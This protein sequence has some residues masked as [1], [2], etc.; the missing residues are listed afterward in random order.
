MDAICPSAI[1]SLVH[2]WTTLHKDLDVKIDATEGRYLRNVIFGMDDELVARLLAAKLSMSRTPD[3]CGG[4][5]LARRGS[6]VDYAVQGQSFSA[7]LVHGTSSEGDLLGIGSRYGAALLGLRPGQS[8]LW[9]ME[10]GR[11]VEVHALKVTACPGRKVA[12]LATGSR[13]SG[14]PC[15]FG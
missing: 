15:A 11:L 9:P 8:V 2:I 10:L 14:S 13:S 12:T 7:R 1:D 5:D 3:P 6:N 4:D